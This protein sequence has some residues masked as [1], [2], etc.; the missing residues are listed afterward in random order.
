L[1]S[2]NSLPTTSP[3]SSVTSML[4]CNKNGTVSNGEL[5]YYMSNGSCTGYTGI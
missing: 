1:D 2:L 5:S 4:D 3:L